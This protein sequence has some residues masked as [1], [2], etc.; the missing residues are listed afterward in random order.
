[1]PQVV[2]PTPF[3][4][5]VLVKDYKMSAP[6]TTIEPTAPV[7]TEVTTA[8]WYPYKKVTVGAS[9]LN[10]YT[11]VPIVQDSTLPPYPNSSKW[12]PPTVVSGQLC[13]FDGTGWVVGVDVTTAS[14]TS[15]QGIALH[16]ATATF[17]RAISGLT[18]GYSQQEQ[19]SWSKQVADA[20]TVISGGAESALIAA[21]ATARSEDVQ[22]LAQKIVT[23]SNAYQTA[24]AT[25]LATLQKARVAISAATTVT[26]LPAFTLDSLKIVAVSPPTV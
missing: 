21:L 18:S 24:Y 7:V 14:L 6:E 16:S 12:K 23:K 9:S 4:F 11:G 22:T 15:L 2:V 10:A 5:L 1:M 3:T 19:R 17:K 25:A 8:T 26:Q 13:Y 20:Q